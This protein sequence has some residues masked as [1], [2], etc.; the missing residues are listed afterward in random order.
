MF[1]I[2]YGD[3]HE[4]LTWKRQAFFNSFDSGFH[5]FMVLFGNTNDILSCTIWEINR[6]SC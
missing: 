1:N 5:G 6:K 3:I 2:T 4:Y